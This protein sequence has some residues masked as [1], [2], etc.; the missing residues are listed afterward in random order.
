MTNQVTTPPGHSRCSQTLPDE[1]H[2]PDMPKRDLARHRQTKP[3]CM[4]CRRSGVRIPLAPQTNFVFAFVNKADHPLPHGTGRM[5]TG[6][7]GLQHA[8]HARGQ[9]FESPKLHVVAVQKHISILKMI[10]DFLHC[11]SCRWPLTSGS[12][13]GVLARQCTPADPGRQPVPL[14]GRSP[15]AKAGANGD[16]RVLPR[17]RERVAV[18]RQSRQ[19]AATCSHLNS[20][21]LRVDARQIA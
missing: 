20:G 5:P 6:T 19:P 12:G 8:W 9:G 16:R 7:L 14:E 18:A 17:A 1:D 13:K 15:G 21:Y 11:Q 2:C 4:A 10:F 3:G